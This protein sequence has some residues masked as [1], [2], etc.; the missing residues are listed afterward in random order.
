MGILFQLPQMRKL[1]L[2]SIT[3]MA[4]VTQPEESPSV[5]LRAQGC[6]HQAAGGLVMAQVWGPRLHSDGFSS[7]G[8]A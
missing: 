7:P 5:Q 1:L 6:A 4:K 3:Q 2:S 8:V